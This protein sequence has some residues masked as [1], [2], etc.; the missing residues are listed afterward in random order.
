MKK[1]LAALLAA[2]LALCCAGCGFLDDEETTD[3]G[4]DAKTGTPV[5]SAAEPSVELQRLSMS[6]NRSDGKLSITRSALPSKKG[7]ADGVWTIFVYLCGADLESDGGAATDDLIEMIDGATGDGV[8]FVVETGGAYSWYNDLIDSDKLQRYLIKNEDIELVDEKPR[9]GMGRSET[10][11]DF[12]KWGV[13]NYASEHM[14]VILWDHGGGSITGICFDETDGDESLSLREV[15]SAL[16]SVCETSGRKF[17]FF[18]FDACLMG[19]LEMANVLASYSDYMIA[20][21]ELEP[22]SGWDY[23]SIGKYLSSNSGVDAL[24]LGTKVCDSYFDSC[25]NTEDEDLVTI[26]LL[27]LSKLDPLLVSFNDFAHGMYDSAGDSA[28]CVEMVR[29]ITKADNFG[30][31]NRSEGYTNMV[32]LAGLISACENYASG[33]KEALAA[34]KNV[35]VYSLNGSSHAGACGISLYYPLSV[36]GSQ[37]LSIFSDI[38]PSPYYIS[39]VDRQNSGSVDI[40]ALDEYDNDFWFNDYICRIFN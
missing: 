12:L 16:F 27:D 3:E 34:I 28:K 24:K 25:K 8:R 13:S 7:S 36:Q 20:S 14:G 9:A 11:E 19:T 33:A 39:F 35:V 22:G 5:S 6:V 29:G 4:G 40:G 26:A 30:G 17:D 32:D 15:D 2:A 1:I 37:E 38:C 21:E 23:T 31:N 10:L 18:G